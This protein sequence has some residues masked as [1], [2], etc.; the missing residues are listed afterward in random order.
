MLGADNVTLEGK[1]EDIVSPSPKF[2]F[3]NNGMGDPLVWHG[4][5]DAFMNTNIAVHKW[6][7]LELGKDL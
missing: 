5:A 1:Y 6:N 4:K 2:H 3:C 7:T